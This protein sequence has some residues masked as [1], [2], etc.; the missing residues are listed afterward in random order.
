MNPI[1]E[2]GVGFLF[3]VMQRILVTGA[4]GFLGYYLVKQLLEK[5]Q[6][7]VATGK[8]PGRLPF[9]GENFIYETLDFTDKASVTGILDKY[10]TDVI[11]HAGAMSKPDECE[12]NREEAFKVNVT[13]TVNLLSAARACKCFFIF[14]SS[15][16]VFDGEKGM[17]LEDDPAHPVNYYGETKLKA[18]DAVK[19]YPF[20][21]S[22]VRT[23]LVY[24]KPFLN[25]SNILTNAATALRKGETLKIFNDQVRTPTYVEDLAAGIVS[26][27][28]KKATGIY[29]LSGKDVM[30]PYEMVLAVAEYLCLDSKFVSK[31]TE[32]EFVQPARRPLKTG[33]NIS[34]AE[35]ELGY[36]PI[37]F[38]EGLSRTFQNK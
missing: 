9:H 37:S 18:E 23:V 11:V 3:L 15:D 25:R 27:I 31:V 21:W 35:K 24:G 30:T 38:R 20:D 36:R 10:K 4:N 7:V 2:Q 6:L 5:K 26:I 32:A 19:Q 22:I 13:A 34:K 28:N 14:I 29:H 16:F 8:G 33:L 1:L 12:T 17:Y